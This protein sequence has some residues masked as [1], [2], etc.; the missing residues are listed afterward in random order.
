MGIIADL[1]DLCNLNR[2]YISFAERPS[3][4]GL[5]LSAKRRKCIFYFLLANRSSSIHMLHESHHH[6]HVY[7]DAQYNYSPQSSKMTMYLRLI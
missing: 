7:I 5:G 2:Y 4:D 1:F 6:Q 3:L